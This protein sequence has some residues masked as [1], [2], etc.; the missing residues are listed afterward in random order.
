M[1]S[2]W[3]VEKVK[4]LKTRPATLAEDAKTELF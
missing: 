4:N 3:V 1:W 2:T